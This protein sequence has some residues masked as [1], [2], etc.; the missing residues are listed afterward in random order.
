MVAEEEAGIEWLEISLALHNRLVLI[1]SISEE[2]LMNIYIRSNRGKDRGKVLFRREGLS[3]VKNPVG[4]LKAIEKS[5]SALW[6]IPE[7]DGYEEILQHWNR[8][9]IHVV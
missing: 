8:V 3:V 5:C 9:Y 2:C 4:I 1:V 7:S 6:D